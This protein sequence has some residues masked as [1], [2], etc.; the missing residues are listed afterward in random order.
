MRRK[1]L[2]VLGSIG[3]LV[4]VLFLWG[5]MIPR[6][7]AASSA[8]DLRAAPE[9]VWAVVRDLGAAPAWWPDVTKSERRADTTGREIWDQ[10]ASGWSMALIVTED[11]PPRRFVTTIEATPD[12]AFG[13]S[14]LYE[15]VPQQAGTRVRVTEHG[16]VS[17]PLFRVV[18]QFAGT[19]GTLDAF[20]TALGHRFGQEVTPE[21]VA[22][23]PR[24]EP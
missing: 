12:A 3:G 13:G 5:L 9:S 19:H 22:P 2:W 24:I 17:N 4:V 18:M 23:S 20:L 10:V 15:I 7:H 1:L 8:I 16:W 21:H 6:E 11:E 14:W